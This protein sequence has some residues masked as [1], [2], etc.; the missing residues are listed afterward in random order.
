MS[1]SVRNVFVMLTFAL[2]PVLTRAMSCSYTSAM[3]HTEDR[4]AI[5]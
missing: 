5:W 1:R 2:L 3:T 4:S